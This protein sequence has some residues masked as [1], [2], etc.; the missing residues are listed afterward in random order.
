MFLSGSF[1]KA[2]L[3]VVNDLWVSKLRK[4][5]VPYVSSWRLI[6]EVDMIQLLSCLRSDVDKASPLAV[7]NFSTLYAKILDLKVCMKVLVNRVFGWM[8]KYLV[9]QRISVDFRYLNKQAISLF[10]TP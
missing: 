5:C 2:L 8:L 7:V 6:S 1:Q 3:P 9:V 10:E 4:A